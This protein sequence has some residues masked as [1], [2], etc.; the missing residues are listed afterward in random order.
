MYR[1]I[2]GF[3]DLQD[4]GHWYEAG[5]LYPREGRKPTEKRIAEL[6]GAKNRQRTALIVEEPEEKKPI[7]KARK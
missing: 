7:K 1:V 6:A 2:K 5:D 4:N 3:F